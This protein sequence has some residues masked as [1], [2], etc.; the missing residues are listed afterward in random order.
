[1]IGRASQNHTESHSHVTVKTMCLIYAMTYLASFGRLRAI[2]DFRSSKNK[3]QIN[4]PL[5]FMDSDHNS[6]YPEEIME[7]TL[8]YKTR[9]W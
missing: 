3:R 6:V 4:T 9:P 7:E 5:K 2:N 1:M 8:A